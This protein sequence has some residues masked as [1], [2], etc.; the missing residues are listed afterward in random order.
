MVAAEGPA[1]TG[2]GGAHEGLEESRSALLEVEVVPLLCSGASWVK[3]PSACSAETS[4]DTGA[5][6]FCLVLG[7]PLAEARLLAMELERSRP[8]L[9]PVRANRGGRAFG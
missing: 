4:G 2:S 3:V 5:V 8:V 1:D 6:L 9:L 7:M